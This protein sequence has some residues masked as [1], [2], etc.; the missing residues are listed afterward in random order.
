M[1][2]LSLSLLFRRTTSQWSQEE[3]VRPRELPNVQQLTF[4]QFYFANLG[5][6]QFHHGVGPS[7]GDPILS[8]GSG[9]LEFAD[10]SV[11]GVQT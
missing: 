6:K 1:V 3:P 10:S 2:S 8:S 7:F 9:I 5:V 4:R 11:P